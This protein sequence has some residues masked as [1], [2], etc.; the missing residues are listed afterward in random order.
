MSKGLAKHILRDERGATILMALLALLVVAMVSTVILSAATST[1]RQ[2]KADQE[3]QQS[4]LDLQSA[5]EYTRKII[6]PYFT[7]TAV[8]TSDDNINWTLTELTTANE[9][10]PYSKALLEA[11]RETYWP[12]NGFIAVTTSTPRFFSLDF[13]YPESDDADAQTRSVK[14]SFVLR[15]DITDSSKFEL[16]FT[17]ST[18]PN[19]SQ[20][21][22]TGEGQTLY[23]SLA[24]NERSS[25]LPT[26]YDKKGNPI[27]WKK[28]HTYEYTKTYSYLSSESDVNGQ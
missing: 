16:V 13:N 8:E 20:A 11:V 28:T 14:A 26:A 5:G 17:F 2:N 21:N 24:C 7:I 3:L 27:R 15:K 23:L 9:D 25:V 19:G 22:L 18:V 6:E 10:K 1:V 12:S 4:L